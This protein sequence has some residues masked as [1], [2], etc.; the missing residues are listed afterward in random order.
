MVAAACA[1]EGNHLVANEIFTFLSNESLSSNFLSTFQCNH[2]ILTFSI[3]HNG[4]H[5]SHF[6]IG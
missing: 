1:K 2:L 3:R 4:N 6:F 5:Y